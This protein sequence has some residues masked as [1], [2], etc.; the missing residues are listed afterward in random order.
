MHLLYI[1]QQVLSLEQH[2]D[3]NL[4]SSVPFLPDSKL[5]PNNFLLKNSH[6]SLRNTRIHI[7]DSKNSQVSV[8]YSQKINHHQLSQNQSTIGHLYYQFDDTSRQEFLTSPYQAHES[9][10]N[11]NLFPQLVPTPEIILKF[12]DHKFCVHDIFSVF[13]IVLYSVLFSFPFF[14]KNFSLFS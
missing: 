10:L 5:S 12:K 8:S 4:V 2:I 7:S 9:A 6:N 11:I 3:I 13:S 1:R 14:F